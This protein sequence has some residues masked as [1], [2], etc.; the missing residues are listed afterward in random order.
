MH[1]VQ[2]LIWTMKI[3]NFIIAI[4]GVIISIFLA[5]S[6][7]LTGLCG[8]ALSIAYGIVMYILIDKKIEDGTYQFL[9]AKCIQV[10]ES[11]DIGSRISGAVNTVTGKKRR[12][13]DYLFEC[14]SEDGENMAFVITT[15]KD[16]GGY[17]IGLTYLFCFDTTY[18]NT[19]KNGNMLASIAAETSP[20]FIEEPAVDEDEEQQEA[21]RPKT[22]VFPGT[23]TNQNND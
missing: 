19:I 2:R 7:L 16:G 13:H 8:I 5:F 22:L 17:S 18:S 4:L 15:G 12:N 14:E 10:D 6:A 20:S 11:R 1:D 3:K 9:Y 21:P 23:K